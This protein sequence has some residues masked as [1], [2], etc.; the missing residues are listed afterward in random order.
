MDL[1][2]RLITVRTERQKRKTKKNLLFTTG[3]SDEE[4]INGS[5]SSDNESSSSDIKI[6]KRMLS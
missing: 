2:K 3:Y 1:M 5:D 4:S 6:P